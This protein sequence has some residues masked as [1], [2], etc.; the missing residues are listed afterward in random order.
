M[1]LFKMFD[2]FIKTIDSYIKAGRHEGA[3][4]KRMEQRGFRICKR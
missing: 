3:V 4:Q 1:D 2:G